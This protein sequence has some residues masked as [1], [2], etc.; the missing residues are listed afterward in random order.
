MPEDSNPQVEII[1]AATAPRLSEEGI[2]YQKGLL[3][4]AAWCEQFPAQAAALRASLENALAATGQDRAP[5]QDQRTAAQRLHD[6]RMGVTPRTADQ[7]GD[8][9][10]EHRAFAAAL[11]LPPDLARVIA[12]ELSN[13]SKPDKAELS[14]LFGD[15]LDGTLK[16]AQFALDRAPG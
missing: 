15:K 5:P 4:D 9:P 1:G 16:D 11:S 8:L 7:Y 2:A 6:Q 12:N 13:G 10:Q 14:R 3:A